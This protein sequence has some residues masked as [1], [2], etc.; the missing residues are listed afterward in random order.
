MTGIV[1]TAEFASIVF[2]RDIRLDDPAENFHEASRL[3][4][5]LAPDGL[6]TML[7]LAANPELQQTALRASRTHDHRAGLDLPAPR[8]PRSRLRDVL[9][10]RTSDPRQRLAEL[11]AAFAVTN[12]LL[13]SKGPFVINRPIIPHNFAANSPSWCRT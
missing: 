6:R 11:D 10:E 8:L 12:A 13:L 4:P 2:G 5:N 3:Y 9:A 7:A 1:P